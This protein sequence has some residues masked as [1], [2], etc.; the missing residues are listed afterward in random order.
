MSKYHYKLI[1]SGGKTAMSP[2]FYTYDIMTRTI[3]IWTIINE[4]V[5]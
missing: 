4:Q 2:E 5:R 3:Q 1:Q